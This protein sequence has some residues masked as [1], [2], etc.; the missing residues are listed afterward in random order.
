MLTVLTGFKRYLELHPAQLESRWTGPGKKA[1]RTR[2]RFDCTFLLASRKGLLSLRTSAMDVKKNLPHIVPV[3]LP[4]SIEEVKEMAWY[5]RLCRE[6]NGRLGVVHAAVD[7]DLE[8]ED[9][10]LQEDHPEALDDDRQEDH[11]EAQEDDDEDPIGEEEPPA[12]GK[13]SAIGSTEEE[14]ANERGGRS[15]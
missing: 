2:L 7:D 1:R 5:K 13:A 12:I 9:D 14:K 11:V 4:T 6:H 15:R 10:D 8:E 3:N